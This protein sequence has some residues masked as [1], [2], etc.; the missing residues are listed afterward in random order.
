MTGFFLSLL[1]I[2][3]PL[4]HLSFMPNEM[5][6]I[7]GNNPVNFIWIIAFVLIYAQNGKQQAPAS[8][9]FRPAFIALIIAYT[10]AALWTALDIKSL[11]PTLASQQYTIVGF[12]LSFLFKPAQIIITG[13]MVYKYCLIKD[14]KHIENAASFIPLLILP[15]MLYYFYLGSGGGINYS[16]GRGLISR[17]TGL[18]ANE[19]GGLSTIILAYNLGKAKQQFTKLDFISMGSSLLVIVFSLSRMSFIATLLIFLFTLKKLT[20]KQKTTAI[21]LLV[22]VIMAFT[23]MLLSRINYGI[24]DRPDT[25]SKSQ[26]RDIN[27]NELSAG[28][29]DYIWKPALHMIEAHPVLGDGLI[30]IWKGEYIVTRKIKKPIHPHNA[31][32]QIAL[33]MGF[34]GI[35]ILIF[36]L[37][38]MWA[39]AKQN[40]GFRYVL[41]TWL[42]M[43]LT[44][45][46]FYPDIFNLPIWVY[47]AITCAKPRDQALA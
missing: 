22:I 18:D 15:F 11:H 7:P 10:V 34:V 1:I 38:S 28:R 19:I 32:L 23:P 13:L 46:T 25:R 47:Y 40:S 43:G 20:L 44:G 41:I 17:N 12:L 16:L 14:S 6:G 36:L 2:L 27:A 33:D 29:V 3:I 31:Y 21:S 30:S 5:M 24:T 35:L 37:R 45:F 9:Y 42:L 39:T 4:T 8:R 26:N